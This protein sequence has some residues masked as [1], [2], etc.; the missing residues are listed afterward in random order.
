DG[1]GP[2]SLRE[3]A[4]GEGPSGSSPKAPHPN[5]LPGGEGTEGSGHNQ[6]N[7]VLVLSAKTEAALR[8]LA[9]RYVDYLAQPLTPSLEEVCYSTATGRSH[10][11]CRLSM[12]AAT[13]AE[14]RDKLEAFLAGQPAEGVFSGV[15][16]EPQAAAVRPT[17]GQL[18]AVEVAQHYV[19]GAEIDWSVYY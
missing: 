3:R 5:P 4:G 15:V 7:H 14:L 8:Q 17:H 2:L 12:V 9:S 18:S 16:N 19:Q 10:W 6:R 13:V 11:H 1:L